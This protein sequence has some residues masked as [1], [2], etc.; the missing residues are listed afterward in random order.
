MGLINT[1][2]LQKKYIEEPLTAKRVKS[3][4]RHRQMATVSGSV[5]AVSLSEMHFSVVSTLNNC[6]EASDYLH[7]HHLNI[8][9]E[10]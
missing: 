10:L 4:L 7:K 3:V 2:L 5:T 8:A 6:A 1:A 9:Q